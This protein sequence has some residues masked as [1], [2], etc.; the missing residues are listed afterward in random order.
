[1]IE[2]PITLA[3]AC[4]IVAGKDGNALEQG[5]FSGAVLTDDNGDGVVEID[6]ESGPQKRQAERILLRITDQ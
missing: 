5:R 4:F 6:F 2:R 3:A 1:M